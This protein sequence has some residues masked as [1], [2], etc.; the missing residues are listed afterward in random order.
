MNIVSLVVKN[1]FDKLTSPRVLRTAARVS[2]IMLVL[3]QLIIL[4]FILPVP[5]KQ[6]LGLREQWQS[7][8]NPGGRDAFELVVILIKTLA[9]AAVKWKNILIPFGVLV[10]AAGVLLIGAFGDE[11]LKKHKLSACLIVAG[12]TGA[13]LLLTAAEL[14]IFLVPVELRV[15]R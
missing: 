8:L 4:L 13:F 10:A 1:A 12:L 9:L 11:V 14:G 5:A 3:S 7:L 15:L 6:A 2:L